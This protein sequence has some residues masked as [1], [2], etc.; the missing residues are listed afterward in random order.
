MID[1]RIADVT[2]ITEGGNVKSQTNL[3]NTY[4]IKDGVTANVNISDVNSATDVQTIENITSDSYIVED[5]SDA[6]VWVEDYGKVGTEQINTPNDTLYI[7]SVPNGY[8]FFFD[9]LSSASLSEVVNDE[10]S[11]ADEGFRKGLYVYDNNDPNI[12]I[13]NTGKGVFFKN[14]YIEPQTH[15]YTDNG[16]MEKIRIGDNLFDLTKFSTVQSR[17]QAWLDDKYNST[18]SFNYWTVNTFLSAGSSA[19]TEEATAEEKEQLL[20]IYRGEE[21]TIGETHYDAI[22]L[23]TDLGLTDQ[24][25]ASELTFTKSGDDLV[26][27]H[28]ADSE[29]KTG[30]FADALNTTVTTFD[31]ESGIYKINEVADLNM[32]Y[33][34]EVGCGDVHITLGDRQAILSFVEGYRQNTYSAVINPDTGVLQIQR[35]TF[36]EDRS[37]KKIDNIYIDDYFS[38]DNQDNGKGKVFFESTSEDR[39]AL[40]LAIGNNAAPNEDHIITVKS[41]RSVSG[42]VTGTFL[43]DW[44]KGSNNTDT[45]RG[46]EG[47]DYI[48]G[49]KGDDNLYGDEGNDILQGGR[50][51]DNLWGGTGSDQFLYQYNDGSYGEDVIKDATKNDHIYFNDE[52]INIANFTYTRDGNNLIIGLPNDES[53]TIENHF[54]Q[55]NNDKNQLDTIKTGL[56]GEATPIENQSI[57]AKAIVNVSVADNTEYTTTAYKESITLGAGATLKFAEGTEFTYAQDGNDLII[58]Y[59]GENADSQD[60]IKNFFDA[61]G[62]IA[63]VTWKY[64]IGSEK[65]KTFESLFTGEGE[66]VIDNSKAESAQII[67]DAS[68]LNKDVKTSAFGDDITLGT[69]SNTVEGTVN[70][71]ATT[72]IDITGSAT[73]KQTIDLTGGV[74]NDINIDNGAADITLTNGTATVQTAEGDDVVVINRGAADVN[75]GA[76]DDYIYVGNGAPVNLDGGAGADHFV[77]SKDAPTRGIPAAGHTITGA[78]SADAID[79]TDTDF[80]DLTFTKS[81]NDLAIDYGAYTVTVKDFF[82]TGQTQADGPINVIWTNDN[83]D[84]ANLVEHG[85]IANATINYELADGQT[86]DAAGDYTYDFTVVAN[87][88]ATVQNMKS[89]DDITMGGTVTKTRAWDGTNG[90][91][92]TLA[93][94]LSGS[95]TVD[96]YFTNHNGTLNGS[97]MGGDLTVILSNPSTA[98][99]YVT[100]ANFSEAISGEGSVSGLSADDKI[101]TAGEPTYSRINNGGLQVNDIEVTDFVWDG[102]HNINVNNGT[103][104]GMTVGVT[105]TNDFEYNATDYAEIIKGEG[106]VIGLSND[107][108]LAFDGTADNVKYSREGDDLIITGPDESVTVQNYFGSSEDGKISIN[109]GQQL[110]LKD[111]TDSDAHLHVIDGT[112]AANKKGQV[113]GSDLAELIIG[114]EK[115]NTIKGG[116]GNDI[117]DTFAGNNKVYSQSKVGDKATVYSGYGKDT[118]NTGL[119]EDTFVFNQNHGNDTVVLNAN[120]EA[121]VL[122]FSNAGELKFTES[123]KNLIVKNTYTRESGATVTET[124]TLKNFL[125][126]KFDNVWINAGSGETHLQTYLSAK[127][128][129]DMTTLVVGNAESKKKQ[130]INGSFLD[131]TLLGGTKND[132]IKSGTGEDN[133]IGNG[134]NDKLYGFIDSTTTKVGK[135][136]VTTYTYDNADNAKTFMFKGLGD[137]KDTIYNSKVVDKIQFVVGDTTEAQTLIDNFSLSKSGNNLVIAYQTGV[138][139]KGKTIVTDSITIAN[140]FKLA[141]GQAIDNISFIDGDGNTIADDISIK[142][143]QYSMTGSKKKDTYNIDRSV[144]ITDSKGNDTYNVANLDKIVNINDKAGKD[145]LVITSAG[146]NG[147]SLFFNVNAEAALV[148]N[149]MLIFNKGDSAADSL[150]NFNTRNGVDIENYFTSGKIESMKANGADIDLTGIDTIKQSVASWLA[151][152]AADMSSI[153][154]LTSDTIADD[155][156]QALLAIYTGQ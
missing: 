127:Q 36:L 100:D 12:M 95:V 141:D 11:Y 26:I 153:E 78:T 73:S 28:G 111:I 143:L 70:P 16:R 133:L 41:S 45:I 105:L 54:T 92:I 110:S 151:N 128:S 6:Y 20:K 2:E 5:L 10:F 31:S 21:V 83:N 96:N 138:N 115:N 13:K 106:T 61:E 98:G 34:F 46:G 132:T 124:T 47:D 25:S 56:S 22:D 80:D 104:A 40:E 49:T 146:E 66:I 63:D 50:G 126:G 15:E 18:G 135:K 81:G 79:F 152:N 147:Y 59:T 19:G 86:F 82:T 103:T 32:T 142:S 131:E 91:D 125:T 27:S 72:S 30:F 17:V 75:T 121:T 76:G 107:D 38:G 52:D 108:I 77:F 113:K 94:S 150:A 99:T 97:A 39:V 69:G 71:D 101:I 148:D 74:N 7:K 60:V 93:D 145:S 149:S 88:S 109:G 144:A 114:S 64:Q 55:Y 134:G 14:V 136:K 139:K 137:G 102:A 9:V 119:G 3:H 154:V 1:S 48:Q 57:L 118:L 140:Y 67:I 117:I 123:G 120:A 89:G 43:G 4:V 62:N 33:D 37:T 84:S 116:G 130:K 35:I 68:G 58:T 85:I 129:V 155:T 24:Y 65:S 44:L 23:T 90:T 29:T 42:D 87:G 112:T 156:K 122:D 53:I 8:T 51:N